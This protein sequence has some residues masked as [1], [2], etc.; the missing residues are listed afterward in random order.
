[1]Q[2]AGNQ[3]SPP[4]EESVKAICRWVAKFAEH[5]HKEISELGMETYIN[6]LCDLR[7]SQIDRACEMT[8]REID[9]MPS[10]AHIRARLFEENPSTRPEY[11]DDEPISDEERT[12]ALYFSEKLKAT[13]AEMD[14]EPSIRPSPIFTPVTSP[15]FNINH[16]A[17]LV[18][19]REQEARDE[20]ARKEGL[21]PTPRSKEELLAM[22]YNLSL[23]E[24]RR[25]RKKAEW[26]KKHTK[27]T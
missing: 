7:A 4:S 14:A 15:N 16:E 3:L 12:E 27:N 17:Y 20:A 25:I 2:S 26:T 13:L 22:F 9:R 6:G 18:W 8:L 23:T 19:L 21:E 1:M 5:F 24:R 11:L 10:V